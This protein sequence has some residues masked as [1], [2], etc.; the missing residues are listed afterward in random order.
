MLNT[1]NSA[2]PCNPNLYNAARTCATCVPG[3][4]IHYQLDGRSPGGPYYS[5]EGAANT[6]MEGNLAYTHQDLSVQNFYGLHVSY[7][8][9]GMVHCRL[10]ELVRS[11]KHLYRTHFRRSNLGYRRLPCSSAEQ[12]CFTK[13]KKFCPSKWQLYHC[14]SRHHRRFDCCA[15]WID[16]RGRRHSSQRWYCP[17]ENR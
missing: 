14:P 4:A 16:Y 10:E 12:P 6:F 15:W 11:P 17:F 3:G 1:V 8:T 7:I 9:Y 13:R 2:N 5:G